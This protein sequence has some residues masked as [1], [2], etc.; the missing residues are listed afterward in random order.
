MKGSGGGNVVPFVREVEPDALALK[1]DLSHVQ[2]LVAQATI[3][4]DMETLRYCVQL[5]H[6]VARAAEEETGKAGRNAG[7]PPVR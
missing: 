1:E 4:D 6:G 2:E 5:L 7:I 3:D